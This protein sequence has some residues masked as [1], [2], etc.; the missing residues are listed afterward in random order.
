MGTGKL[1]KDDE[2]Q[3]RFELFLE[4]LKRNKQYRDFCVWMRENPGNR[5]DWTKNPHTYKNADVHWLAFGDLTQKKDD[6]IERLWQ[7][8]NHDEPIVRTFEPACEIDAMK[9]HITRQYKKG[10]DREPT[11]DEFIKFIKRGYP[12]QGTC[13][14]FRVDIS[15]GHTPH[16]IR[17]EI[18][19]E[20][21]RN[22]GRRT[23]AKRSESLGALEEGIEIYDRANPAYSQSKKPNWK[24]VF[25]SIKKE[26]ADKSFSKKKGFY[27]SDYDPRSKSG[28]MRRVYLKAK[29]LVGKAVEFLSPESFPGGGL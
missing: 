23:K 25:E 9:D 8:T 17:K 16:E 27:D 20:V 29:A 2:G 26:C 11:I 6:E 3:K 5:H 4:Y 28:S 14:Y 18:V 1:T 21:E 24:S 19:R 13:L 15:R 7:R 22:L 12:Q 10:W